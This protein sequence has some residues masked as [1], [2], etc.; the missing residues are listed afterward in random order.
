MSHISLLAIPNVA[1]M[2]VVWYIQIAVYL[3]LFGGCLFVILYYLIKYVKHKKA[4]YTAN[5]AFQQT[6]LLEQ[7]LLA[8]NIHQATGKWKLILFIEYVEKFITTKDVSY[9]TISELLLIHGFTVEEVTVCEEVLYQDALLP[10]YLV[11]KIDLY[12]A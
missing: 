12:V 6:R 11:N 5:L 3:L 9:A 2:H 8:K 1:G 4:F 7:H 10:D